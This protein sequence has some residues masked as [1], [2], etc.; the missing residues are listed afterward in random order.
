MKTPAGNVL[1]ST[2]FPVRRETEHISPGINYFAVLTDSEDKTHPVKK[3]ESNFTPEGDETQAYIYQRQ[4]YTKF[5]N[6]M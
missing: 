3:R 1:V 4:N 6:E 5:L 2:E